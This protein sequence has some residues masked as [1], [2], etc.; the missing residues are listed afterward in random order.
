MIS[1]TKSGS[2]RDVYR[3]ARKLLHRVDLCD[4]AGQQSADRQRERAIAIALLRLA[5]H[6]ISSYEPPNSV[7]HPDLAPANGRPALRHRRHPGLDSLLHD[8]NR[9]FER[10]NRGGANDRPKST[11]H[12]RRGG[13]LWTTSS[14]AI[15]GRSLPTLSR[16]YFQQRHYHR[17]PD[18]H[19]HFQRHVHPDLDRHAGRPAW[20][21]AVLGQLR[22]R[23]Y[24]RRG[25]S[26]RHAQI[27]PCKRLLPRD[28]R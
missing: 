2:R 23:Q 17:R 13:L 14:R 25:D 19:H 27:R 21:R 28:H 4:D 15:I 6:P 1:G 12:R 18:Q 24:R 5:G 7:D 22:P 11:R 16:Q 9:A 3:D 10:G 8:R 20:R 26:G